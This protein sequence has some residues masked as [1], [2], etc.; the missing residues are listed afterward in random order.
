VRSV[1]TVRRP[2]AALLLMLLAAPDVSAWGPDGHKAVARLAEARLTDK[3]AAAVHALLGSESLA[4]VASWADEVRNTTHP[5]TYNWHFT[6]VPVPARRFNRA[7]DCKPNPEKGDCSVAALERLSTILR[8]P[9]RP[10]IERREALKF[11]VHIVG[12]IHQPLHSAE[13]DHDQGGNL[14]TVT[15]AGQMTNLHA[16]WDRGIIAT[17]QENDTTLAQHAEDWLRS[18]QERVIARGSSIDWTNEGHDISR[19]IV[20]QHAADHV[21]DAPER[22]EAIRIIRKRIGRAGVRLASVLNRAFE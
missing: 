22:A 13:R 21:I 3:A 19:D 16:A 9:S 2:A 20:Y 7:R 15:L 12:D 8:D 14:V 4:D 10:E 5:A 18:Q 1:N 11:I 17:F 6:D